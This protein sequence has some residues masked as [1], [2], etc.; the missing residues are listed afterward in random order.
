MRWFKNINHTKYAAVSCL[1]VISEGK[2][3]K[4][5]CKLMDMVRLS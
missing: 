4:E 2:K 5:N 1:A 3:V